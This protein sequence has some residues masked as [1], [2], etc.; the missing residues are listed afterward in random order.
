MSLRDYKVKRK[1]DKTP[2]PEGIHKQTTG[3]L[4]F[5]IQK[6]QASRL[7]YDFRLELN[8][9]LKSWAIPR[10]PSLNPQDKRLAVMVEDHPIDYEQ[11]EGIIPKDNYGAGTVMVWDKGVY[12][13]IAF[14]DR[15]QAQI[16]LE[17]QI[18]AEHLTFILLGEKLQGEFALVKTKNS[19][20]NAWL[21]FKANDEYA[22]KKDIL[23]QDRSVIS[24]RSLDQIKKQAGAKDVW[25]IN[26]AK[27]TPPLLNITAIPKGS[28]PHHV[29][30][31]LAQTSDQPFTDK[32]WLFEMK[33]DGYRAIAEIVSGKVKLY[34]RN[35]VSFDEKFSPIVASLKSFPGSAVFDGEV[36][37]VDKQGHPHFQWLQDYPNGHQGELAYFVFDLL[38]YDGHDLTEQPLYRR[39]DI[40]KQILP[41]LPHIVYSDHI[42][43]T[44]VAMFEQI[45]K[46]GLEGI[47]AKHMQSTYKSGNRTTDWLKIKTQQRQE[48]I[49]AGFTKPKGGRKHFG[50]LIIGI[51]KEGRLVCIGHVGGG[52]DDKLL[53]Q[54][55]DKLQPL[56][57]KDCPFDSIPETN[58]PAT[59][60]KPKL[61]SEIT[62]SNWTTDG[63]VRHPIFIGLRGDKDA[64]DATE[65]RY[66]AKDPIQKSSKQVRIGKQTLI[67]TNLSKIFWPREGYTKGD[68]ISYYREIAPAILSHLKDRP[69][70]MLRY[71]NGIDGKNFYQKDAANLDVDW[72]EKTIIHSESGKKDIAYL[73]CQNEASMVYLNNLGCID[74]NPWSSRVGQLDHPD[75]LIID[76]D[77]EATSFGTVVETALTTREVLEQLEIPSYVK[78]SGAKGMH[79]YIPLGAKYTYVQSRNLA[80]LLCLQV[81]NKIP[82]ITS[83]KRNPKDRQGLVYLDYLQNI[84]GQTLASVYS[85]RAQPGATVSTPLLWSEVNDRLHPSQFTIRNVQKRLQKHGDLFKEVLGKGITMEKVLSNLTKL[86]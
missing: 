79:I 33:Y 64:T 56:I 4:R 31:M 45:Q 63:Q 21:L 15:E 9:V 22:K 85:V 48:V 66:F 60:V 69:Q 65:E 1:F 24:G 74:F 76:L 28:M 72:I 13:P 29:K 14:V 12:S 11:F 25:Y 57:Q 8:G 62:F 49:I 30:P 53:A 83:M 5:V 50:S 82:A 47:M 18:K 43:G 7:H 2:E 40:L 70:S 61:L 51:Y 35:G 42:V 84:Q 54:I 32:E 39:K 81:H 17:E 80:E 34:S 58:A 36:V 41:P 37:V 19:E 10:G 77:P 46:L 86:I 71:P 44:G 26:K 78:T 38:H 59:W 68:V 16:V 67:L 75:Y 27:D 6:H 73:L 55:Y 20:E 52:F 23:L 3:P